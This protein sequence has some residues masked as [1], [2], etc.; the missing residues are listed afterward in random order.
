MKNKIPPPRNAYVLS[1][2]PCV[3]A[4]LACSGVRDGYPRASASQSD[5]WL[6]CSRFRK[7]RDEMRVHAAPP[8]GIRQ[9]RSRLSLSLSPIRSAHPC[10]IAHSDVSAR[11]LFQITH[12][13]QVCV[14][15]I[16]NP[17]TCKKQT[18]FHGF[19]TSAVG[20]AVTRP[21]NADSD[22]FIFFFGGGGGGASRRGI[23]FGCCERNG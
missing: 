18:G 8:P 20:L 15:T 1:S 7:Q 11:S 13:S 5:I 22:F 14:K 4:A 12:A 6:P 2:L 21:K 10:A 17:Q 9:A 19:G 23:F 16:T 3:S